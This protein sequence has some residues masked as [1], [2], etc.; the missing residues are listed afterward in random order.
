M[1][2]FGYLVND[3]SICPH[4]LNP[5]VTYKKEIVQPNLSIYRQ[6]SRT[7]KLE[8]EISENKSK[9]LDVKI[10][11]N[12]KSELEYAMNY[13]KLAIDIKT[14]KNWKDLQKCS[15]YGIRTNIIGESN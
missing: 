13:K 8:K 3:N 10:Q 2:D 12:E 7:L 6:N 9:I 4:P 14:L 15:S 11:K 1:Q 5:N